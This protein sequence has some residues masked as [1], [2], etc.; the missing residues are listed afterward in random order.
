MT[1]QPPSTPPTWARVRSLLDARLPPAV[2]YEWIRP[3]SLSEGSLLLTV[4]CPSVTFRDQ[5]PSEVEE[6]IVVAVREVYGRDMQFG[7]RSAAGPERHL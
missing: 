3:L 7:W 1:A 2:G 5:L 4:W 6:A